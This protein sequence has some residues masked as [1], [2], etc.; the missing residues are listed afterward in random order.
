MSDN[1]GFLF[2]GAAPAQKTTVK[3][4]CA[5]IWPGCRV[6]MDLRNDVCDAHR[7][8]LPE[9]LRTRLNVAWQDKRPISDELAAIIRRW[10]RDP[11]SV[12]EADFHLWC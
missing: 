10:V 1:Q 3:I 8:L 2:A 6:E 9:P 11:S 7:A 12:D 5:C 4:P